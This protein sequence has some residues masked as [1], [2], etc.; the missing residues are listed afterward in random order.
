MRAVHFDDVSVME[1]F[2]GKFK[3][4]GS[5]AS[6][7]HAGHVELG[8]MGYGRGET[9]AVGLGEARDVQRCLVLGQAALLLFDHLLR[10]ANQSLHFGGLSRTRT[11]VVHV[12]SVT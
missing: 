4:G 8:V 5:G 11:K 6:A 2:R 1:A 9:R 12:V 10:G 3:A 7:H